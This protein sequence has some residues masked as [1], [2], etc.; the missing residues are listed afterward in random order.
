MRRPEIARLETPQL[1]QVVLEDLGKILGVSG[2]PVF[3]HLTSW[4]RA[5]PQYNVGFQQFRAAIDEAEVAMPGLFVGGQSRDGV[6]V[7]DCIRA[8]LN[9]AD[10]AGV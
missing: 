5:I 2:E 1:Q 8:G 9:L 6:S 3:S 7:G 10:K 4:P